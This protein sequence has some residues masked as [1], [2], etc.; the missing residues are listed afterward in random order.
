MVLK[1]RPAQPWLLLLPSNHRAVMDAL[2]S[3][4]IKGAV[5]LET[6]LPI[7][8]GIALFNPEPLRSVMSSF[9]PL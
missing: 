8:R 3:D 7:E 4:Q 9:P 1:T 5:Q 2:S 6:P